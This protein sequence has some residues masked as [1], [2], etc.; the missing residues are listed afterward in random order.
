MRESHSRPAET[1]A[2]VDHPTAAETS[3]DAFDAAGSTRDLISR[4][5]AAALS[6]YREAA[7]QGCPPPVEDLVRDAPHA[8]AE[9]R[10][11]IG[12]YDAVRAVVAASTAPPAAAAEI[13]LPPTIPGYRLTG[14][15]GEGGMG[16]VYAA[17]QESLNRPV[18]VKLLSPRVERNAAL[19][20]RFVR[21]IEMLTR[22]T[23][24][25]IVQIFDAGVA[26]G[27]H[28]YV[29]Q[30]VDGL[31]LAR[32]LPAHRVRPHTA[33]AILRQ[34]VAGLAAAHKQG[35]LH[36]DL[37]PANILLDRAGI[38]RIADFGLASILSPDP[39]AQ[40]GAREVHVGTLGYASPEQLRD[41]QLCTTRSDI[42]SVGVLFY[43]MLTGHMPTDAYHPASELI[44]GCTSAVDMLIR[45]CIA[46]EPE[47]RYS[48]ATSLLR[49]IQKLERRI[50]RT[51]KR[52]REFNRQTANH[53]APEAVADL[54]PIDPDLERLIAC[55]PS[56]APATRWRI[57][58][59]LPDPPADE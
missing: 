25:N 2:A 54:E 7:A 30:H 11:A 47:R 59:L 23:H 9:I 22:L 15:L 57:L 24:P 38:V 48:S 18:A 20:A 36:R 26:A 41:P 43:Q 37:K 29:M 27:R 58:D 6:R 19:I 49:T 34:L 3:D 56:L 40:A 4:A 14:L 35:I 55:W 32:I 12:A 31:S 44:P 8:E 17:I 21:E 28:Y 42:Y 45:R 5:A 52:Q 13:A 33:V 39:A 16:V 1:K 51:H 46:T 50:R 53:A 10:R